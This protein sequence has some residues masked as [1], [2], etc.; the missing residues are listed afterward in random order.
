[1]SLGATTAGIDV[2][3][4]VEADPHAA[5]S[6]RA[7]HPK[8]QVLTGDVR[9]LGTAVL[10]RVRRG[11]AGTILFGGPPCQGFSY[12]NQRTRNADNPHNWLFLEFVRVVRT[13]RPDWVVF[14]NVKG[15]TNTEAGR[16]L[17]Q[18][19]ELLEKAGYTLSRA[20]LDAADFGVPQ[21]RERLFIV[22]SLHGRS[23]DLRPPQQQPAISVMDA[24]A[25]LPVL[26]NGAWIDRLSYGDGP[27][28][29]YARSMRGRLLHC[30]NHLVTRNAPQIIRRYSYIPEGG[31]WEDIPGRLMRN[32]ADRSRC[33]TG[34]YHRLDG[35]R[36]SV[37]IGNYRKNMLIHPKQDRGLSVREAARIQSFPDWYEFSGSIGFRQQQVGNAVPPL[38]AAGVFR[39]ILSQ[40]GVAEAS[41]RRH[42]RAVSAGG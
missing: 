10:R 35:N 29:A 19:E 15:I 27:A 14:E 42:A 16:F 25:D 13:W 8:T 3:L 4:A 24:I 23:V 33:H 11:T 20:V 2:A 7:N 31:N 1:M 34:I 39:A 26:K 18:V 37:V 38:L 6:Y 5:Q 30:S 22:G 36:P 21:H 17:S 12:S 9:T 41:T 28:S 32:Y 40:C